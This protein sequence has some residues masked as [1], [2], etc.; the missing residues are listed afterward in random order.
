MQLVPSPPLGDTKPHTDASPPTI[1]GSTA[2]QHCQ[3]KEDISM[4]YDF[5]VSQNLAALIDDDIRGSRERA[6]IEQA[7]APQQHVLSSNSQETNPYSF[8]WT[9]GSPSTSSTNLPLSKWTLA[10]HDEIHL[11][12]IERIL[13]LLPPSMNVTPATTHIIH[14]H[15]PNE[16]NGRKHTS[17]EQLKVLQDVFKTNKRP[18]VT[19]RHQLAA[20]YDTSS[21]ASMVP[22]R[23]K[24]HVDAREEAAADAAA[25]GK[26]IN[27]SW[28]A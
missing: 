21:C 25:S 17:Q 23:V 6:E 1:G 8:P 15:L 9:H 26:R 16:A 12:P 4:N 11:T 20:Q 5:S 3:P 27:S 22:V 10:E 14:S 24:A 13:L 2:F 19:L 7:P 28:M 18:N